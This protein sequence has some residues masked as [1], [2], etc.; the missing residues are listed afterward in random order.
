MVWQMLKKL[1]DLAHGKLINMYKLHIFWED[2]KILWNLLYVLLSKVKQVKISQNFVAFSE[3]MNF[4]SGPLAFVRFSEE[5][6]TPKSPFEINWP[7]EAASPKI[8]T[9]IGVCQA[10]ISYVLNIYLIGSKNILKWF[11]PKNWGNNNFTSVSTS[12][13]TVFVVER[14]KCFKLNVA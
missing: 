13:V 3:Y 7:L 14:K 12:G 5:L 1:L 8:R 2:H 9:M 11:Q 4:N 6:K 10:Q